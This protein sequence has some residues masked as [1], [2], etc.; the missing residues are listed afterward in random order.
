M[1]NQFRFFG[2]LIQKL[3]KLIFSISPNFGQFLPITTTL[4]TKWS[5]PESK[6]Q[7]WLTDPSLLAAG[8]WCFLHADII[9]IESFILDCDQIFIAGHGCLIYKTWEMWRNSFF[10]QFFFGKSSQI[11]SSWFILQWRHLLGSLV[12]HL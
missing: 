8:P 11:I 12:I 3:S 1:L 2:F 4:L 6:N 5:L 10:S 9:L 7:I